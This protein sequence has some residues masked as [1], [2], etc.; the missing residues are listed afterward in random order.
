MSDLN[1]TELQE[2]VRLVQGHDGRIP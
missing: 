1:S 2:F